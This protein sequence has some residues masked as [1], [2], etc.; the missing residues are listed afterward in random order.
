[1][2]KHVWPCDEK[3]LDSLVE[4]QIIERAEW[5]QGAV[6]ATANCFSV[7]LPSRLGPRCIYIRCSEFEA[8]PGNNENGIAPTTE[9]ESFSFQILVSNYFLQKSKVEQC[10]HQVKTNIKQRFHGVQY[11]RYSVER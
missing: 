5:R 8:G 10:S 4:G 9:A 1:M 3:C 7:F 2:T 11:K 6:P